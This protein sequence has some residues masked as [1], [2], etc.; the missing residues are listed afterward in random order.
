MTEQEMR[1]LVPQTIANIEKEHGIRVLYAAEAGSRARGIAS[2]HSDFDVRFLYIRPR[3]DYLRL[4][5]VRDVLELPV[6]EVWDLSGW[7]LSKTLRLLHGGNT[8]IFEW[9]NS[10]IVYWD[11][12]FADRFRQLL[13]Q[14]FSPKTMAH[15]YL[16]VGLAHLK[17]AQ[18]SEVKVKVYLYIAQYL[19]G[20]KYVLEHRA[21]PPMDF[22]TLIGVLPTPVREEVEELLYQKL[23]HPEERLTH[24]RQGLYDYFA[25]EAEQLKQKI[26][27]LPG[28]AQPGWEDLNRFFLA[29]LDRTQ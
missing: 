14:Y 4:E 13:E 9:L 7:D 27:A 17:R 28:E 21:F 26:F 15:Y 22:R 20:A 5:E 2:E 16:N 12:D 10:P 3:E 24:P 1:S 8:Q 19:L 25:R 11:R 23:H 18:G 6:D 29:E